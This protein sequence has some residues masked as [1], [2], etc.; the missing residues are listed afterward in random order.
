MSFQFCFIIAT[1][2]TDA[3]KTDIKTMLLH[4]CHERDGKTVDHVS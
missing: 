3:H 2:V 1:L 4:K